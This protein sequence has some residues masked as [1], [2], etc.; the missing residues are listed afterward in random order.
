MDGMV[1]QKLFAVDRAHGCQLRGLLMAHRGMRL[2]TVGHFISKWKWGW[3]E[4]KKSRNQIRLKTKGENQSR[5]IERAGRG[6]NHKKP[7][8]V[9][10][11]S[12]GGGKK[13]QGDS[14]KR[15]GTLNKRETTKG[16]KSKG[17]KRREGA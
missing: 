5:R 12:R 8:Q 7:S 17:F 3:N 2:R 1:V 13:Y 6:G 11:I 15:R 9:G 14:V 16:K 4:K 10:E